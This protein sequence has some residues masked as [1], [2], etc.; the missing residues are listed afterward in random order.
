MFIILFLA[1]CLFLNTFLHEMS[2]VLASMT[3]FECRVRKFLP[4]PHF[5]EGRFYFG[6]VH[7][8][9]RNLGDPM[10]E[11]PRFAIVYAAPRLLNIFCAILFPI[12]VSLDSPLFVSM[13]VGANLIDFAVGTIG[14]SPISDIN[15]YSKLLNV[16]VWIVRGIQSAIIISSILFAVLLAN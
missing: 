16:N 10:M 11:D 8:E 5:F 4:F 7:I 13:F 15:R 3:L 6:M 2:H 9:Y 14:A 1:L 12:L